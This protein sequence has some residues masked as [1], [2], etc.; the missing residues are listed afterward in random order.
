MHVDESAR[1]G[2][3]QDPI[4]ACRR[5]AGAKRE[6]RRRE[7]RGDEEGVHPGERRE[8]D[9]EGG[10]GEEERNHQSDCVARQLLREP[11]GQE[12]RDEEEQERR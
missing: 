7:H 6:Q 8:R 10:D 2:P 12:E 1:S 9:A 3:G 11:A 4:S 5:P